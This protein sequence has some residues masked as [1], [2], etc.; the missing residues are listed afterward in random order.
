M[1]Y[2]NKFGMTNLLTDEEKSK[3]STFANKVHTMGNSDLFK[4]YTNSADELT[5]EM[6]DI[7]S[8]EVR[9]REWE[10]LKRKNIDPK[11]AF[12]VEATQENAIKKG[13]QDYFDSIGDPTLAKLAENDKTT[14]KYRAAER[15]K[16]EGMT[17]DAL[18]RAKQIIEAHPQVV[19][20]SMLHDKN[21]GGVN[22]MA[23]K[24][25]V[26]DNNGEQ[27]LINNEKV[28]EHFRKMYIKRLSEVT[29]IDYTQYNEALGVDT[30]SSSDELIKN[31]GDNSDFGW[32]PSPNNTQNDIN[33][34]KEMAPQINL[35]EYEDD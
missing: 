5:T 14:I 34:D 9:I 33:M 35:D 17:M 6:Q 10:A 15:Q 22:M 20:Q 31:V 13:Q 8:F 2:K 27:I 24:Y 29:G 26:E 4:L 19:K 28:Q 21:G 16:L 23:K 18:E 11:V 7:V 12:S 3:Y 1:D 30:Y 25:I 32:A